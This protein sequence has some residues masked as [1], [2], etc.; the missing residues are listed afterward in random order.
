MADWDLWI[1]LGATGLPATVD[2]PLVAYC[3][4]QGNASVDT[5]SIAREMA[6]IDERYQALRH[7]R[8]I[9]RAYVYRWIAWSSLRMGRR[10][11][12]LRAYANAVRAG[13]VASG[14]RAAVGLVSPA[15]IDWRVRSAA[16]SPYAQE[17]RAWLEPL[18]AE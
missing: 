17:A 16:R 3:L 4:H 14:A 2:V 6:I 13:D 1:R 5:R 11:D 18:L 8:S 15:A 10:L 9:D 7:G 12:A